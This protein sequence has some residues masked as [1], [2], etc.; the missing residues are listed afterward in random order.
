MNRRKDLGKIE[1]NQENPALKLKAPRS[2]NN[3][4]ASDSDSCETE[5]TEYL[6]LEGSSG[7]QQDKSSSSSGCGL[8]LSRN[9]EVD[10]ELFNFLTIITGAKFESFEW[11]ENKQA[12]NEVEDITRNVSIETLEMRTPDSQSSDERIFRMPKVERNPGMDWYK[13][14]VKE[15]SDIIHKFEIIDEEEMKLSPSSFELLDNFE[16]VEVTSKPSCN[17]PA[18]R[19][20][21]TSEE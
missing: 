2:K 8:E 21:V 5:D 19:I 9:I 20:T 1:E 17:I 6:Q 10:S 12:N 11:E 16:L 15:F 14:S 18:N 3:S 4:G 7:E 13:D